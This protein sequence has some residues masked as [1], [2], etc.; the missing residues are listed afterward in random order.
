MR[1]R[2]ILTVACLLLSQSPL[3]WSAGDEEV[4]DLPVSVILQNGDRP[5]LAVSITNPGDRPVVLHTASLPWAHRI[6]MVLVLVRNDVEFD[7]VKEAIDFEEPWPGNT[8]IGPHETLTGD[9]D[10]VDRFPALSQALQNRQVIV[11][12]TYA[13]KA[14]DSKETKRYGA[15]RS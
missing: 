1:F 9:V 13:G 8:R 3:A 11:F 2:Y 15:G 7:R 12:W 5:R 6:Y 10:L 4:V 14:I